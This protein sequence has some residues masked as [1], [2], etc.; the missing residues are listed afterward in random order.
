MRATGP[1]ACTVGRA[2]GRSQM[3]PD[4]GARGNNNILRTQGWVK[5]SKR[6]STIFSVFTAEC[7]STKTK[8]VHLGGYLIPVAIP[9]VAIATRVAAEIV[10]VTNCSGGACFLKGIVADPTTALATHGGAHAA[11]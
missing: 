6:P 11:Q 10:I 2:D 3:G 8:H 7:A 4:V 1:S 9:A 5:G